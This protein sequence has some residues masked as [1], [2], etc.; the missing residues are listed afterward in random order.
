MK[1]LN[2]LTN[3][4]VTV[5]TFQDCNHDFI[6]NDKEGKIRFVNGFVEKIINW[7]GNNF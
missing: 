4:K 3:K 2:G 5:I 7:L 6:I 1:T